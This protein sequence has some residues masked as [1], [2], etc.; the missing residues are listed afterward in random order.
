MARWIATGALGLVLGLGV[1]SPAYAQSTP[2]ATAGVLQIGAGFR[3]GIDFE[4]GDLNPFGAGLGIDVGLTLPSAVYFGGVFDYFFGGSLEE[5]GLE[6]TANIWQFMAEG[7]YDLALSERW[8][9][10]GKGGLG[11]AGLVQETCID[12][13]MGAQCE[14]TSDGG[15]ALAPG[16]ALMYLGESFSFGLNTRYD[17]IFLDESVQGLIFSVGI[18]F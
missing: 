8:V 7:G 12:Q 18:G 17:I 15:F 1:V 11:Y 10:R 3:Y 5:A 16:V 9:F 6:L 13:G 2:P 14:D 4:E